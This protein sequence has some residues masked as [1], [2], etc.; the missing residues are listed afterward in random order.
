M[1][2][3]VL[4]SVSWRFHVR[5]RLRCPAVCPA[6]AAPSRSDRGRGSACGGCRG[7]ARERGGRTARP[8]GRS[9]W[10]AR[11]PAP[12]RVRAAHRDRHR[13]RRRRVGGRPPLLQAAA[14][15]AAV[16]GP[17]GRRRL[18]R[19][20]PRPAQRFRA[21]WRTAGRRFADGD[22]RRGRGRRRAHLS[23]R[24]AT[25][26]RLSLLAAAPPQADA[27]ERCPGI[28]SCRF[29][30]TATTA[31]DEC[32]IADVAPMV[33]PRPPAAC[34]LSPALGMPCAWASARAC[35][36]VRRHLDTPCPVPCPCLR[37]RSR[38]PPRRLPLGS[39]A[40]AG[41]GHSSLLPWVPV[42]GAAH[43]HRSA[44]VIRGYDPHDHL[45]SVHNCVEIYDNSADWVTHSSIQPSPE[46][47]DTWRDRWGKPV[48]IDEM[49]YEGGVEWGAT[50]LPRRWSA[51][52]GRAWCAADMC[53]YVTHGECCLADDDVLW[54]A[55]GGTLKGE[56]TLDCDRTPGRLRGSVHRAPA[57]PPPSGGSPAGLGGVKR[58]FLSAAAARLAGPRAR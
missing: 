19:A 37:P 42:R 36:P 46:N 13:P 1:T 20:R 50:S 58:F 12:A 47:T 51:D 32:S 4:E 41:L 16:A 55:K 29:R 11:R 48:T 43:W 56:S 26:G 18:L 33:I 54:R 28:R 25:A 3:C 49:G 14:A 52:A 23:A 6:R 45:L 21:R 30:D 2:V 31:S 35:A 34:C 24:P 9:I 53:G 39:L 5:F 10:Q 7:L 15:S 27:H 44:A 8:R 57:R 17:R 38:R 22:A 40:G